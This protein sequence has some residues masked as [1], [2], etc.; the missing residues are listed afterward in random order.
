MRAYDLS[1]LFRS[2]IG[3]DR[4]ADMF[5]SAFRAEANG[6]AYPPYNI[7]KLGTDRYRI[8]MA[9]AGFAE[10]DLTVTVHD[11][12]LV[13]AGAVKDD[14]DKARSFLHRGIAARVFERR[15]SLAD[16]VR[17]SAAELAN[18]LLQVELVR[19]IPEEM[20]PRQVPITT[21][22]QAKGPVIEGQK[23]A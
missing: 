2:T 8:T 9:V 14:A 11:D 1:P 16:H 3:F 12:L 19:E 5:D 20:K 4:L 6:Q 22:A 18:G 21:A 7:E 17:V 13:I 15:F 10:K 23:A